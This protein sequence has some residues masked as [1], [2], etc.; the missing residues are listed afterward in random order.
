[1]CVAT[2]CPIRRRSRRSSKMGE[3]L[4]RLGI[5]QMLTLTDFSCQSLQLVLSAHFWMRRRLDPPYS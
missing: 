5:C 1:M 4:E 2:K 3:P